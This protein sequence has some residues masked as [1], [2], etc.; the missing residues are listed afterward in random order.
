M[1]F[2]RSSELL[3]SEM[4]VLFLVLVTANC[5]NLANHI[6]CSGVVFLSEASI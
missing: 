1:K 3:D 6:N 4:R 2:V 5:G